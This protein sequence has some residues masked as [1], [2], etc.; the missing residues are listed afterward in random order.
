MVSVSKA[1][2]NPFYR[3][4]LDD[5]DNIYINIKEFLQQYLDLTLVTCDVDK[6]YCQGT[7][8]PSNNIFWIDGYRAKYGDNDD[9]NSKELPDDSFVILDG[10]CWLR[11]DVWQNWFPLETRWDVSASYLS[12]IPRFKLLSERKKQRRLEIEQADV[13]KKETEAKL[14]SEPIT[15]SDPFRPE[16]KYHAALRQYPQQKLGEDFNYDANLDIF[17]GTFQAGGPITHERDTGWNFGRPYWVYRL[18]DQGWFHLMEIGDTYFEESNLLL[19]NVSAH[20]GFKFDSR[21]IFYG[22]G[23]IEVNG[24][25]PQNTVVDL[26]RSGIYLS[27]VRTGSDGR[28]VFDD[29]VVASSD[30]LVAKLYYPDGAEEVREIVLSDDNGMVIPSGEFQERA[31]TGETSYGR[32]NYM[33][34][35]YGLFDNVTVGVHPMFFENAKKAS[36]MGDIAMRPTPST[37]FLGQG[38]FTGKNIDRAFRINS[39]IF[40]PNFIQL[41]HRYYSEDTPSFLKDLRILGEYWAARHRLGIGRFQFLNEYEQ[42]KDLRDA[43]ME[44]IY[45]FNRY[46]KPFFSYGYYFPSNTSSYKLMKAGFDI[47]ATEH[48]VLEVIRI[49]NNPVPSSNISFFVRTLRNVG[50]WDIGANWNIP[51]RGSKSSI[52]ANVTYRL[53]KNL[54][55]GALASDKYLGF[56]ISWDGVITPYP[57]PATWSEFPMGTLSGK[58]MS[59]GDANTKPYPIEDARVTVGDRTT[60]TDKKGNFIISGISSYQKLIAKVDTDSLDVSVIPKKEFEVVYFRPGTQITWNPKLM[61]TAGMDGVIEGMETIPLGLEVEAIKLPENR[62]MGRV[63]VETDGFFLMEKMTPGRY[64]LRLTGLKEDINTMTVEIPAS[65]KWLS[66]IKWNISSEKKKVEA[67]VAQNEIQKETN[68][69]STPAPTSAPASLKTIEGRLVLANSYYYSSEGTPL[70]IV[71]KKNPPKAL[72]KGLIVEAVGLSD[73]KVYATAKIANNGNFIIDKLPAGEY[74][75][76]LRGVKNPPRPIEVSLY[77]KDVLSGIRWKWKQ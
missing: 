74:K 69:V 41:E 45:S 34:L 11:Y 21:Q 46:F 54:S 32:M 8:Q 65:T 76:M 28:Y 23:N 38:L 61:P 26:Y 66:G 40:Y 6:K 73:A 12:V 71:Q 2:T 29:V 24:R 42:R 19:P 75:L 62:K 48:S 49:W 59:P 52:T 3:V 20:N 53:T 4:L 63:D 30:R 47:M 58:I 7:L 1:K 64:L 35:R 44:V 68:Q 60:T 27:T 25:A 77:D 10:I 14:N 67:K 43:T 31:F 18:Q 70:R 72:P 13:V 37:V 22:S 57:G 56:K 50:G 15:P 55:I 39:T 33:A 5:D 36:V 9:G 51:D 17:N 16:L